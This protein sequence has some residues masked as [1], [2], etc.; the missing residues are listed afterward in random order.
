MSAPPSALRLK[1]RHAGYD[2]IPAEGKIPPLN[3]WQEKINVGDDDICSWSKT[4]PSAHNTGV[5]AKR[6]PGL[7]IDITLPDAA[8]ALAREHFEERGDIRVRTGRAPRRLIPLR[9][10]EPFAKLVRTFTAPDGSVQKIEILS[11]GQ[12]YIVAG[13]HPDTQNPYSW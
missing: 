10:D 9:T 4:Y 7:D 13:I 12:Q 6:A 11:D 2:P 8:E 3:G 5:L 1:L